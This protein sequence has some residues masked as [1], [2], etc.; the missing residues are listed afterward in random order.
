[1]ASPAREAAREALARDDRLAEAYAAQA[2]V[3][4][5]FDWEWAR[6]EATIRHAVALEPNSVDAHYVYGL[7]L[8]AMGR[9]ADSIAQIDLAARVDPL[10]AQVQSTFGRILYRARR[11]DEAIVRLNRASELEPR[12]PQVYTRLA[13]VYRQMGRYDEALAFYEKA[14]L[15]S[16]SV[17]FGS[18]R[19]VIYA[20]MGRVDDARRIL[21]GLSPGEDAA[22]VHAALGDRDAAFELLFR[23]VE[24]RD[25]WAPFVKAEPTFDSLHGDRRWTELLR[26]M[27][28]ESD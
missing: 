5:M 7:L 23:R 10:S 8:M 13:D 2:Y 22:A 20:R 6:A 9:L 12:N 25:D 26:R 11:F 17:T 14:E 19:A 4:G 18:Q 21:A 27:R 3:Q 16:G 15:V 24:K 28:L 1:V